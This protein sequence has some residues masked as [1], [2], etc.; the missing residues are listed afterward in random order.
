MGIM[1][2]IARLQEVIFILEMLFKMLTL[3]GKWLLMSGILT[4]WHYKFVVPVRN[5][6]MNP[7][8]P[9]RSHE[10]KLILEEVYI[11]PSS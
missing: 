3:W 7:Y 8:K 11:G 10:N 2:E 4:H 6:K 9:F 1:I 5:Y